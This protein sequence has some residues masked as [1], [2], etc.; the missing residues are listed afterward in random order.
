MS[1]KWKHCKNANLAT[2]C[3]TR[4]RLHISQQKAT[5]MQLLVSSNFKLLKEILLT[6]TSLHPARSPKARVML[7]L[8][9]YSGITCVENH[10]DVTPRFDFITFNQTLSSDNKKQIWENFPI[11]AKWPALTL[12]HK[13]EVIL[14][15]FSSAC[16]S[17]TGLYLMFYH[18][19][20]AIFIFVVACGTQLLQQTCGSDHTGCVQTAATP[21]TSN[22]PVHIT[23]LSVC[24]IL[25]RLVSTNH[26]CAVK[27]GVG[28][29]HRNTFRV[30]KRGSDRTV[31]Y[32]RN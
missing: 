24:L 28:D 16:L 25:N 17:L 1:I 31:T 11:P 8:A 14:L 12:C 22:Q 10:R 18:G 7:W 15:N 23:A 9:A 20:L 13:V 29:P 2:H 21:G 6:L 27:H 30:K 26:T 5:V 3:N 19:H 4:S 32:W